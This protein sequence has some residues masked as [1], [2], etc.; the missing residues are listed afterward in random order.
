MSLMGAGIMGGLGLAGTI[1]SALIGSGESQAQRDWAS[2]WNAQNMLWSKE[3]WKGNRTRQM[4]FYN[5]MK[6]RE[7][8]AV[9]RRVQDLE[10]AGLSPLLA[11]GSAAGA[12]GPG[13]VASQHTP[14]MQSYQKA[15]TG[16]VLAQGLFNSLQ[17]A[18]GTL[19]TFKQLEH[20]DM[21]L[22]QNQ[23]K[24]DIDAERTELLGKDIAN[25]RK[26]RDDD[27]KERSK[28]GESRRTTRKKDLKMR[29]QV[30]DE[31]RQRFNEW[32]EFRSYRS[33]A[34]SRLEQMTMLKQRALSTHL[35]M[36]L[37]QGTI[38]GVGSIHRL[39]QKLQRMAEKDNWKNNNRTN[40]YRQRQRTMQNRRQYWDE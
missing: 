32:K 16:A 39:V 34:R 33:R 25:K 20:R 18:V 35:S 7:D 31:N 24:I 14:H 30:R 9:Q 19:K 4:E 26:Y 3:Q 40:Y 29:E 13:P 17:Q 8:T 1:G 28:E 21:Q 36:L 2:A 23:Q 22:D 6:N 12:S 10:A 37:T 15:N 11:A 5:D 38:S 27:I